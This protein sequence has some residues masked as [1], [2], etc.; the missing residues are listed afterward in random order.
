MF[1]FSSLLPQNSL[2]FLNEPATILTGGMSYNLFN[3]GLNIADVLVSGCWQII[4]I[5]GY[6]ITVFWYSLINKIFYLV[7]SVWNSIT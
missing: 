4:Y 2:L 6:F 1:C 3:L 7:T 5:P